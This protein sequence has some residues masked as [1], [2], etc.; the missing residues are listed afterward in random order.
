MSTHALVLA[1]AVAML[2][3]AHSYAATQA[4]STEADW[5][6]IGAAAD[7]TLYFGGRVITVGDTTL[8]RM[9]AVGDPDSPK[10]YTF[11]E[12]FKCKEGTYKSRKEGW[13]KVNP[14][15]IG[16]QWFNYACKK[17]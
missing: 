14:K 12:A 1:A 7:D 17:K 4:P 3:A 16:Q 9:K 6:Y 8:I 10:P 2:P 11:N 5:E 15:M 13:K